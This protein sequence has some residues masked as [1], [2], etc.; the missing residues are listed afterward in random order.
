[1]RRT[2]VFLL[3]AIALLAAAC[4]GGS[5]SSDNNDDGSNTIRDNGGVYDV[6][7]AAPSDVDT[8]TSTDDLFANIN[9]LSAALGGLDAF[10]AASP[11]NLDPA[12]AGLLL[13]ESDLPEAFASYGDF[14]FSAGGGSMAAR[15]FATGDPNSDDPGT[16]V[17]SMV[18]EV[19]P[20]EIDQLTE[21]LDA[22]SLEN[23][24]FGDGTFGDFEVVDASDLG[25]QAVGVHLEIDLGAFIGALS[26][27]FGEEG[28]DVA[29]EELPFE[30][31]IALDMYMFVRGDKMLMV[32]TVWPS[33]QSARAD[34]HSLAALLSAR[35]TS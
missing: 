21:A 20:D 34:A 18:V 8:A 22:S 28:E 23:D 35:T 10:S 14:S 3:L 25:D 6:D 12:L 26:E 30:S 32:S 17:M 24:I 5:K 19:P 11:S 13:G 16:I 33:D 27:A 7:G 2:L 4:G 29:R 1:M 9:P 31:G 15:M